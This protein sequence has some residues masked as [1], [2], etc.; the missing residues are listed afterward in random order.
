MLL[1]MKTWWRRVNRVLGL[2]VRYGLRY[3]AGSRE[4]DGFASK[5]Q[6]RAW[7]AEHLRGVNYVIY[8]YEPIDLWL[9]DAAMHSRRPHVTRDSSIP[10]AADVER[11]R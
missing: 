11:V 6:A 1:W 10:P 4:R 5:G 7:A 3:G 2:H 9:P 8:E